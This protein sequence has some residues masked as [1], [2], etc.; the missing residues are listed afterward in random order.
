MIEDRT[1]GN[2]LL[3]PELVPQKCWYQAPRTQT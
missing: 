2:G 1:F 3:L